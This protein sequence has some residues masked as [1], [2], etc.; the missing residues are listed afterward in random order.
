MNGGRMREVVRNF[1]FKRSQRRVCLAAASAATVLVAMLTATATAAATALQI[2]VIGESAFCNAQPVEPVGGVLNLDSGCVLNLQIG[3][4]PGMKE[5]FVEFS[6]DGATWQ[7]DPVPLTFPPVRFGLT[8]AI[9]FGACDAAPP[10]GIY[11]FRAHGFLSPVEQ[12]SVFSA[13][14]PDSVSLTC[15]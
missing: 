12:A 9:A 3:W 8:S 6:S 2:P 4:I 7:M 11:L 14:F 1:R 10:S 5:A 13:A 15:T